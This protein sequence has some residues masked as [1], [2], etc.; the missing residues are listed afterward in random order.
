MN[1]DHK[2]FLI[3]KY[4]NFR[5]EDNTER[6]KLLRYEL[7][8]ILQQIENPDSNDFHIWGLVHYMSDDDREYHLNLALER[9]T[10]AYETDNQN[11]MA[12]LYLAHCYQDKGGYEN[13]LKYYELVNQEDLK[14]F[15]TWRYVKLIEQI[16]FCHYKLEKKDLGR[17][18]F[19]EVIDWYRKL[20]MED[21]AHPTEILKCLSDS[22]EIVI[23]LKKIEDGLT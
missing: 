6:K 15:Q 2:D 16:G 12:C 1:T 11:F 14:H 8:T 7:F 21:L 17:K 10:Q 18:Y 20:P 9:F 4:E 19:L 13:A 22:D 3:E 23:E 5:L